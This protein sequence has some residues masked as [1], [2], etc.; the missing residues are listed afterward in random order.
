M[1]DLAVIEQAVTLDVVEQ[2]GTTVVTQSSGAALVSVVTQG[3]QG[4]PGLTGASGVRINQVASAATWILSHSLGRVPA[5]QVFLSSGEAV[6][7]DVICT[8]T[9]ITVTFSQPQSGF[10]IAS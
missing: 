9:Q 5:V 2:N 7:A 1:I 3:P 4:I 8:S 10:V 6:V